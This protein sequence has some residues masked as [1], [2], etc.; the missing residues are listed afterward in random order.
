MSVDFQ[1]VDVYVIHLHHH[2][3]H[4]HHHHRD[5]CYDDDGDGVV[6]VVVDDDDDDEQNEEDDDC[7]G[8]ATSGFDGT[9]NGEVQSSHVSLVIG[10]P[11]THLGHNSG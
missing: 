2:H 6:V 3:H 5:G 11:L 9:C 7:K 4:H 1:Y 8:G 10:I